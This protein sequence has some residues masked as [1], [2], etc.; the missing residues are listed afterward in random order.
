MHI[1][2]KH[3]ATFSYPMFSGGEKNSFY[4]FFVIGKIPPTALTLKPHSN[5]YYIHLRS[6]LP[7][8]LH[9]T[10]FFSCKLS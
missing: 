9:C 5:P 8:V 6:K 7:K 1:K 2:R 3:R 10:G 4:C